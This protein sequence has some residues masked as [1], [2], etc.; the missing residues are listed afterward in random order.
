MAKIV[1]F[2]DNPRCDL[3]SK[4]IAF[5]PRPTRFTKCLNVKGWTFKVYEIVANQLQPDEIK[6]AQVARMIEEQ[7]V[8]SIEL[9]DTKTVWNS[10]ACGFV[11]VH[12]GTEAV[13]LLVDCWVN[14]I[15]HHYLFFAELSSLTQFKERTEDRSMACVWELAVIT[16]ERNAWVQHVMGEGDPDYQAYFADVY[17]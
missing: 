8:P 1:Q 7:F 12:F 10:R 5:R 15:L 4:Q 9:P 11:I 14:D 17:D 6:K 16:H 13:W 3:N 2:P